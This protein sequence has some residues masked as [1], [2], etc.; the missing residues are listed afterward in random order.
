MTPSTKYEN[1]CKQR[2]TA[3]SYDSTLQISRIK[4]S[5][6]TRLDSIQQNLE[7]EIQGRIKAFES[8]FLQPIVDDIIQAKQNIASTSS[9]IQYSNFIVMIL[10]YVQNMAER[11]K[12]LTMMQNVL[13]CGRI[14][15]LFDEGARK[16]FRLWCLH[17]QRRQGEQSN[18]EVM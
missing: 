2:A 17:H 13:M 15:K 9:E 12:K 14:S 18:H 16:E 7:N 10:V 4:A 5:L 11:Q 3:V 8:T 6:S 1:S